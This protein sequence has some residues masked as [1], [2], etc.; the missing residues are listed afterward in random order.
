[1][2]EAEQIA[3]LKQEVAALRAALADALALIERQQQRITALE[4][5][6]GQ[7]SHN[8]RWP[9]GSAVQALCRP[10]AARPLTPPTCGC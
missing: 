10:H 4:A 1:M 6:L 3:E 2:G 7:D 8:S 9:P 5:Q